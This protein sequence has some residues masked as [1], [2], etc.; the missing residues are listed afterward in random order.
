MGKKVLIYINSISRFNYG[1]LRS[2]LELMKGFLEKG[3]EVKF[4]VNKTTPDDVNV[5]VEVIPL[6][7][8]GDFDRP[9]K[10]K[11]VIERE[12]PSAVIANMYTQIV[13]ASFAKLLTNIKGVKYIGVARDVRSWHR[14]FWKLPFR[15][16]VKKVY[17]NMDAIVA[18]SEAVEED[19]KKTF[20][21]SSEKIHLIYNPVDVKGI[22]EQAKEPL[23][24]WEEEFFREG[25]VIAFIGRL[26]RQKAPLLALDIFR[27]IN[28]RLSDTR[29]CFIGDGELRDE[30]EA[31]I[32]E[33]GLSKKVLILG[34]RDNPYKYM[35]RSKALLHTAVREGLGRVIIESMA[36]GVP[37]FALYNEF[38]GY[39]AILERCEC[40]VLVPFN[41]PFELSSKLVSLLN[42]SKELN[43]LS[44]RS[45]RFARKFD[46]KNV[47]SEYLKVLGI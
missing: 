43:F 14:K 22:E 37:V 24:G 5:P 18:I 31:K 46:R 7:A 19:I 4:V 12:N 3:Y 34:Y 25:R 2:N 38:S 40:G 27:D 13:T 44:E 26:D 17:E 9:F 30:I 35:K 33:Y 45:Y 42:N 6:N 47:I 11:G 15:L 23:D 28:Q 8:R 41:K 10:L 16:F 20:F 21:V 36:L 39:R 1:N 29:L 32:R